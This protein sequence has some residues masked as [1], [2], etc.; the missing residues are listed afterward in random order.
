MPRTEEF[1]IKFQLAITE[2]MGTAINDWRRRQPDIP[3]RSEAI[4]RLVEG[5]LAATQPM[6]QGSEQSTS[7]AS[8]MAGH[9]IDRLGDA[10][11]T[12]EER[13]TRKRRLLKGPSEFRDMRVD[14]PKKKR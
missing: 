5:R 2:K 14:Q 12:G 8:A 4:R 9:H 10:S 6:E 3:N 13:Q 1:P 7:D 11:A